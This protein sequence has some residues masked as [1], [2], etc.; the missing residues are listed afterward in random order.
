ML[1]ECFEEPNLAQKLINAMHIQASWG[2]G[3]KELAGSEL[4]AKISIEIKA[5][6]DNQSQWSSI[7]PQALADRWLLLLT[8]QILSLSLVTF[9]AH[10]PLRDLFSLCILNFR[11]MI[12]FFY[13]FVWLLV[14]LPFVVAVG[15]VTGASHLFPTRPPSPSPTPRAPTL[16]PAPPGPSGAW[17]DPLG[18]SGTSLSAGSKE[19]ESVGGATMVAACS[20]SPRWL[21]TARQQPPLPHHH[22][23]EEREREVPPASSH[24]PPP[25]P[26]PFPFPPTS[27]HSP[28]LLPP[29]LSLF[30][31]LLLSASR[32][33]QQRTRDQ[34][35]GRTWTRSS[36]GMRQKLWAIMGKQ[37]DLLHT[38]TPQSYALFSLWIISVLCPSVFCLFFVSLF[39]IQGDF[40]WLPSPSPT[41]LMQG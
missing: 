37:M 31:L 39:F 18:T 40:N 11:G 22:Q 1:L 21:P 9:T 16:P 20:R 8:I 4:L 25:P 17:R 10:I 32:M 26:P 30:F 34:A 6:C 23:P 2:I 38:Q 29:N 28:S 5:R 24:P 7:F 35:R 15:V 14:C 27:S 13:K 33:Q 19:T 3:S 36:K 12:V 41:L